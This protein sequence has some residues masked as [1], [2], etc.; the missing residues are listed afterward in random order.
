M[1]QSAFRTCS[2]PY[3]QILAAR[4]RV[5][6]WVT[7]VLA[8]H[9]HRSRHKFLAAPVSAALILALLVATLLGR[10]CPLHPGTTPPC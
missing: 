9:P 4:S 1:P 10:Q 3:H 8:A 2:R 7:S 5:A 6:A